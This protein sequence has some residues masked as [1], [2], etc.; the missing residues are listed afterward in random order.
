M[1]LKRRLQEA[2]ETGEV[3]RI[4]YHGGSQPG[5]VRDIQ[6]MRVKRDRVLAVCHDAKG[7]RSFLF[8]RM[9]FVD[10]SVPVSYKFELRPPREVAPEGWFK[11][12]MRLLS[13]RW[14][15]GSR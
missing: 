2:A 10:E 15:T 8:E 13:A 3:L 7:L 12:L 14:Q 9:E 1:R 6:P 5:A 4:R 11:R